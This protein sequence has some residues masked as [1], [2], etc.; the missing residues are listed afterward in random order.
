LH[1]ILQRCGFFSFSNAHT[2]KAMPTEATDMILAR[3]PG[4]S[5]TRKGSRRHRTTEDDINYTNNNVHSNFLFQWMD[6]CGG[7]YG[8]HTGSGFLSQ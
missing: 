1:H 7:G 5:T 6:C 3:R 8:E 4:G 2:I